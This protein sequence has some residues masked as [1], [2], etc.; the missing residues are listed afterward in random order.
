M[1]FVG[2]RYENS[3]VSY[4]LDPR[5]Q[6]TRPTVLRPYRRRRAEKFYIWRSGDR[7]DILSQQRYGRP[8]RWWQIMDANPGIIDPNSIRPGT[9]L[10]VP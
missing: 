8:D 5:A 2:S 10:R 4:V 6:E 1:I 3:P 7:M 9:V